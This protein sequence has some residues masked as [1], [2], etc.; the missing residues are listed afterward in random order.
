MLVD[1]G[2]NKYPILYCVGVRSTLYAVR[3]GL[4]VD[5]QMD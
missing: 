2:I 3:N 5:T 1:L 4:A